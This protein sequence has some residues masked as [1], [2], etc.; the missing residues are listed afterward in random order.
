VASSSTQNPFAPSVSSAPQ[1]LHQVGPPPPPSYAPTLRTCSRGPLN[2]PP[3]TPPHSEAF[4]ERV[5]AADGFGRLAYYDPPQAGLPSQCWSESPHRESRVYTLAHTASSRY[6]P[7]SRSFADDVAELPAGSGKSMPSLPPGARLAQQLATAQDEQLPSAQGA[8]VKVK[9]TFIDGGR[10][11][12]QI[13]QEG[14]QVHSCPGSRRVSPRGRSPA[15]RARESPVVSSTASTADTA[16][17]ERALREPSPGRD[18]VDFD[19]QV[20]FRSRRASWP[21]AFAPAP[22][23]KQPLSSALPP[24]PIASAPVAD[25]Q[26]L[27]LERALA[28]D[29]GHPQVLSLEQVLEFVPTSASAP[30]ARGLTKNESR[31]GDRGKGGTRPPL[32][33]SELPSVGSLGHNIRRCKPCAF[34]TRSGCANGVQCHFCHLCGYGEKKRRRKEKRAL[35]GVARRLAASHSEEQIAENG[36]VGC[37]A[38]SEKE[39]ILAASR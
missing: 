2:P 31:R 32:G 21:P 29:E 22:A 10:D 1:H 14:R 34:A 11:L 3:V 16:E 27:H 38:D 39:A 4:L 13:F 23:A 20:D 9:N 8:N 37:F 15:G 33:S 5:N 18:G 35:I 28:T 7:A 30:G 36:E 24:G 6:M 25:P 19:L 17:A 26:P 12:K